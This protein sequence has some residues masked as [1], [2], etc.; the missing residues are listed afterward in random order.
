MRLAEALASL[1]NAFWQVANALG[2]M[3]TPLWEFET[4]IHSYTKLCETMLLVC[5]VSHDA[6]DIR[7]D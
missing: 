3:T 4:D 5:L 2:P 6:L 7:Q 1:L